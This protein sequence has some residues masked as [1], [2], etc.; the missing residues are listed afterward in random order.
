M[1][2]FCLGAPMRIAIVGAGGIGAIFGAALARS[3]AEVAFVARGRTLRQCA[4]KGLRIEGDRGETLIRPAWATDDIADIGRS[5]SPACV[6]LWDVET[7]GSQFVRL[8]DRI[9]RSS[10]C[11]TGSMRRSV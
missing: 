3:G 8:S 10:R 6:K 5:I 7:A 4:K 9:R 2:G 11:R 1:T